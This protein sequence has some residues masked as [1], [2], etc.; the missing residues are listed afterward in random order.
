[1]DIEWKGQVQIQ[2]PIEQ[3]FAYLADF[4]RHAEWAQTLVKMEQVREGNSLGIGA[5]YRTYER[6][7]MQS[8]RQPGEAL[9]HGMEAKTLCEI[10]EI[11]P[12]KRIAW[13]SHTL[14]KTGML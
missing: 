11:I 7:A 10:T 14:P 3:V 2:R 9:L 13:H 4:Q 5:V 6:Q 12:N 8:N 1:M